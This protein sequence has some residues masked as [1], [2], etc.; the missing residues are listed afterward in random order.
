MRPILPYCLGIILLMV[1]P[2]LSFS[3][4]DSDTFCKYND[5][6]IE[7]TSDHHRAELLLSGDNNLL[8][9]CNLEVGETYIISG[10]G[11]TDRTCQFL[12]KIVGREAK[13]E[14]TNLS[15]DSGQAL[16]EFKA[17]TTCIDIEVS[18]STC[19]SDPEYLAYMTVECTSCNTGNSPISFLPNI[20][21][22]PNFSA[23][24]LVSDIFIG[25][26]CFDVSNAS[27]IGSD[28][29]AGFFQNAD[30]IGFGGGG[31]I[32]ASGN[33][34]DAPGPAGGTA[35]SNTAP[36]N[37]NDPD[38]LALSGNPN[39]NNCNGLEFDF[40][41]TLDALEFEFV[42]ASE[43]YCTFVGSQYN[44]AFGFFVSGPGIT[45]PY[46]LGAE[47]IA[48][49]PGTNTEIAINNV[50]QNIN[51]GFF[52]PNNQNSCGG[53]TNLND[54][55][56][57]G[58]TD[59]FTATLTGLVACETY[60][61]KLIVGDASDSAFDSAVFLKGKSFDA[62]GALDVQ[63][64]V[65][66][67]SG[68]VAIEACQDGEFLFFNGL[69]GPDPLTVNFTIGGTA[70]AG[71]DYVPF[72][73][74]ITIPAGAGFASILVDILPDAIAEGQ[75]T[76][77]ITL[78]D[79]A[80]SCLGQE[81]ILYID[82][83][84]DMMV[85]D[86]M[87]SVCGGGNTTLSPAITGGALPYT[88]SWSNGLGNGSSV[89]VSPAG[90]TTYTVTITDNCNISTEADFTVTVLSAPTA[91][92]SGNAALCAEDPN[93]SATL[94]VSFTGVGPWD[95]T[96]TLN[97]SPVTINGITDN[98]YDLVVTN[99]G[100]YTLSGVSNSFCTGAASGTVNIQNIDVQLNVI[101]VNIA[102][103]GDQTGS[104]DITPS[105]GDP[106]YT[107]AWATGEVTED[108]IN[109]PFG[110]YT[111]TVTDLNGCS[112]TVTTTLSEPTALSASI[113]EVAPI[114]CN[115]DL[116]GA[117]D[118]TVLGGAPG[119][120]TYNWSN[121]S[122][123]EDLIQL[124]AGTYTVTA[125]DMNNCTIVESITLTQPDAMTANTFVSQNVT[126]FGGNNGAGEL[127]VIGGTAPFFY[128]WSNGGGIDEDPTGLTAGDYTV[129][130]T[131]LSGCTAIGGISILQPP[132][133]IAQAD[134]TEGVSCANPTGGSASLIVV[135]G[136]PSYT[137]EW[138][139]GNPNQNP[140]NLSVGVNTVTITDVLG[141]MDT[142]EVTIT[143]DTLSP[144]ADISVIG[145]IS[146]TNSDVTLDG[147]GS[148]GNGVLSYEWQNA[149]GTI[150]STDPTTD[151]GASGDYTLI[152]T[153]GNNGCTAEISAM[154]DENSDV[155][156][157]AAVI[158]GV[159]SCVSDMATLDGSSSTGT[160]TLSYEWQN[161][162]GTV[163]ANVAETDIT[164]P[165]EYTLVVTE[166]GSGCTSSFLIDVPEDIEAPSP[167]ADAS[168]L[169]NCSGDP[170]TLDGS[171]S[172]GIGNLSYEW[173]DE[174][175]TSLG[176]GV[177]IDVSNSGTFTLV[178]TD[179]A[180]GC[181]SEVDVMV[182]ES[183]D[184]PTIDTQVSGDITCIDLMATLDGSGSTGIGTLTYEWQDPTGT[185]IGMTAEIDV[186][187]AG[188]YVLIITDSDN[189]CTSQMSVE[190]LEDIAAPSAAASV[191]DALDCMMT[192]VSLDGNASTGNGTLEY[193]WQDPDDIV[194]GATA[195][196]DVTV[197]GIYTLVITDMSNGC[198][199]ET[200]VE[201][202]E[203]IDPP[204]PDA[205]VND[206]LSCSGDPVTLDG[207][208]SSGN[209]TID[210]NWTDP[211]GDPAGTTAEVDVTIPGTY[212][213]LITDSGNGCT[214]ETT[215]NV[216][217]N[218]ATPSIDIASDGILT[219]ADMEVTL[220]GSASSGIGTITYE[221][222][223]SDGL[224]IG[225]GPDLD[226][227]DPDD[228]ILVITDTD[229]GCTAETS[230]M[231][232]QD[233]ATPTSNAGSGTSLTCSD[234]EVTLDGSGSTTVGNVSYEWL[235]NGGV[236]V[237]NA[238]T[239]EVTETGTYTLIVTNDDN[240][241]TASSTVDV[242]PDASL[243]T[244]NAG[245]GSAIT[246]I[247]D[248]VTL[249]GSASTS[250]GN[251]SY[252]WF[253]ENLVSISNDLVID[254]T[255]VGT[256]TLVV[257]NDDNGC[258]ASSSVEVSEDM[259]PPNADAGTVQFI[260]CTETDVT[261]DGSDSSGDNLSYQWLNESG[262]EVGTTVTVVVMSAETYTLIVTNGDNGCTQSTTVEVQT[263]SNVPVSNA[264]M[265]GLLNCNILNYTLDGSN[266][267][268]GTL[269]YEW[270]DPTGTVISTDPMI[271]VSISGTY[272]LVVTDT[273]NGCTSTST[274]FVDE[275]IEDPIAEAGLNGEI[276][277]DTDMATLDG[278]AST[279][280]TLSYVW[281]DATNAVVGMT[282][283]LT[284][285]E[286]GIYTLIITNE[287]N[288]CTATDQV[289]VIGSFE[290][291]SVDP[292]LDGLLTCIETSA[293]LD[294]S[295]ST[296]NGTIAYEWFDAS[297]VSLGNTAMV[298]TELPGIYTLI[299]TNEDNGCTES[300][301]VEVLENIATPTS[302]AGQGVT[303]TCSDTEVTLSGSGTTQSGNI[304]YE[305][306]NEGGVSI[307]VTASVQVDQ[308]GVYTLIVTDT[309]NGCTMTSTVS[310]VPDVNLPTASAGTSSTLTCL[311]EMATLDGSNSSTGQN[312]SYQWE[313]ASNAVIG[314]D[315]MLD[316]TTPGIY[317]IVV[318]DTN[319][320]CSSS[321]SVE[322]FE[323]IETPNANAGL[324][325][326]LS[327]SDMDAT[328]DGSGSTISTG[329]LA[330]EWQNP[331]GVT[332]AMT[333]TLDVSVSGIYTLIVTGD[334][335][336]TDTDVV[337]ILMDND[338]PVADVGLGGTLDCNIASIDLGGNGTSTGMGITHEWQDENGV[339]IAMT[340]TTSIATPGTY[341]LIVTNTT[342]GCETE[343]SI[344]IPEDVL[345][346]N[347]DAGNDETLTCILTAYEIGGLGTSMGPEFIY[348][349][350]NV[351]GTV[352]SND[353]VTE[354]TVD[355]TYTLLITN[356]TNG[357]T[358][359]EQVVVGIDTDTPVADAGQGGTLTCDASMVTLDGSASS[360]AN[361]EFEWL[362]E[363]GV[364]VSTLPVFDAGETGVYTLVVT[365]SANGCSDESTASIVPDANLPSAQATPSG[366]LTCVNGQVILDG[367]NSTSVSGNISY[368][369]QDDVQ[370]V[371]GMDDTY[372]TTTSGIYVL[373]VTDT[374]NGCT[375]STTLEVLEDVLPPSADAGTQQT[376]ICGQT[377]VT[378]TGIGGNGTNLIYEWQDDQGTVLSNTISV[379]VA[380]AGTYTFIVTNT[381]NGCT[382]SS[383]VSVVPDT[384]L[385][386]ADAG[387]T[388]TLTCEITT[389]TLDGNA[390]SQG[391]NFAY[392][393][394]DAS[395][396][397][398]ST[399]L[400]FDVTSPGTYT[401]FVL[402]TDNNCSS[403]DQ[404]VIGED[405]ND[406][407]AFA[408]YGSA[409]SLDCNNSSITLD[410]SG[411]S[412]FGSL[413]FQWSTVDGN[414]T[415]G[416][417]TINPEIN[418]PGTYDLVVTNTDN[419]CTSTTSITV[420]ENTE[421]PMVII[422]DPSMLTCDVIEVSIDASGSSTNGNYTYN[423]TG[424]GIV[425][426]TNTLTPIV[427][428]PGI[429]VCF[430]IDNDNGCETQASITVDENT[431]PPV[432]AASTQEMFDCLTESVSLSGAGSS[433]GAGISYEWTGVGTIDNETTLD[434]TVYQS[435]AFTLIVTDA[436]NGCTESEVVLVDE[437]TD[438]PS[439]LTMLIE[440]PQCFG[441]DGNVVVSEVVGG[442]APYLYSIDNGENFVSQNFFTNLAPG[443]YDLIVQDVNG[444]E[445]AED[446][447]ID[448]PIEIMIEIDTASS[449]L[450]QLGED[451]QLNALVNLDEQ[452][453]DTILWSPATGLSCTD[454]LDPIVTDA[455]NEITYT[456]TVINVN[457]CSETEEI[458]L[459][460]EKK[461]KVYIPNAFSP[462][463]GGANDIFMIYAGGDE[464]QEITTFQVFDRW[465]ELLFENYNF[466]P[467]D[468]AFGWNG[469]FRGEQLNPGVFVY[470]AEV[471]FIDGV[472]QIVK[473]DVTITK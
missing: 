295:G 273:D 16:L 194:I 119:G 386:T 343:Q 150:I 360:G 344:V 241:C 454:C 440:D 142:T 472:K 371:L 101:P 40:I 155:P 224:S 4:N 128:S 204:T 439:S 213:L 473:G 132:P 435:G 225:T 314:M 462:G 240:G 57:D 420:D 415:S 64:E 283:M 379:T 433:T 36:N 127:T 135:G 384:N 166:D 308:T 171:S 293:T 374:D 388:A 60:H 30:V 448:I 58:F 423:W 208:G 364:V 253:D 103:N 316:V 49:V 363:A 83:Y 251:I 411:S 59:V 109:V 461:R 177:D 73:N 207:S 173:F 180:N 327:C 174:T 467:N 245:L 427:N 45:G 326:T 317:T 165:G 242:T 412:P 168:G 147:T 331:D 347:A 455:F 38:L 369:W 402:N 367:T 351:A 376:L 318:T 395:G 47:N 1:F 111:V 272:T 195:D 445:Y 13:V 26:D 389:V 352:I 463:N 339:T 29:G 156:T 230:F 302:N 407:T 373:I 397:V 123:N 110:T 151:V 345:P 75:E 301:T 24:Q 9:F 91:T 359:T 249:D 136:N 8:T 447:F 375:S 315:A 44:D 434:P 214:A 350:T 71:V 160:G 69:G 453:I 86:E 27:I 381:D 303:L 94:T 401:L 353:P 163:I 117:I 164:T 250:T 446:L 32:L 289:E 5:D 106:T 432:A 192:P 172:T 185:V 279:G 277:C 218:V 92:L 349:W 392:E 239:V 66:G 3:S 438:V 61:I 116:T 238:I 413:T 226:V 297:N 311:V 414:I 184:V 320:G 115:G 329:G 232:D 382:T 125:T 76:I 247:V 366:M 288:G 46:S 205:T 385:P 323:N 291:P 62:G 145:L 298:T 391:A 105:G 112:E 148:T 248:E 309:D 246:C 97:G 281:E 292:G 457:G 149:S 37:Q 211:N 130:V 131:D 306:L 285:T 355:D 269:E 429:F 56:Y 266:S 299:I 52:N 35:S 276:D 186:A 398:I 236:T 31:V 370:T 387:T 82:D 294:G 100:S 170:V 2:N 470:W 175:D 284:A 219:C 337:E 189:G 340:P 399:D 342:S 235:N 409:Q 458:T 441:D 67:A 134:E 267:T 262:V 256:Y 396:T 341:T 6:P 50:N 325:S 12:S 203:S 33:V 264:G 98:P 405:V 183:T 21:V 424:N 336:C 330:Y 153:D 143:G 167:V 430:I 48:L 237:G 121:A 124:G 378:L 217:E 233:I 468:P 20:S 328:L 390:S 377:D 202:L 312:I 449:V 234:T 442:N 338:I 416:E 456:V 410:G 263:D 244:A 278:G 84:E 422:E 313:D 197:A 7:I 394:Q 403:Q 466:Q 304:A 199:A 361:I 23:D 274:A 216:L 162:G 287:D 300:S 141:C 452:D 261:L 220:D 400:M 459:R 188:D 99:Q 179:D 215:V 464:I 193:E 18:K 334:N 43:E 372:T 436:S 332:V 19:I 259:T 357:C 190:L 81:T 122:S 118:L 296:A 437:D 200:T 63:A 335:G 426:G 271:D 469:M 159:L 14:K 39:M 93:A 42:F 418:Q 324:G 268:G 417:L 104:I 87:T 95:I 169:I 460:V 140:D 319:N 310:V 114:N 265:D 120:Y 305:W 88:Y 146:C 53:T 286:A 307:G 321:S 257:T 346:P 443:S 137:F 322:V 444:C 231:L 368:E 74:S 108:L 96:Y 431:T 406:P 275:D 393:W 182:G 129:T 365:N 408:D 68:D 196:L 354:V 54:I 212:T 252:E 15:I 158:D 258:S 229:N 254:V 451:Y 65:Q 133:I 17:L 79:D 404:V 348:E 209:G 157:A 260:T 210:Y 227:A 255:I 333:A 55:E 113:F 89:D 90:T 280:G 228:Y 78:E 181:T 187:D 425:S 161:A 191:D 102:C 471:E 178:I 10:F 144:S 201:V 152:I 221:W 77:T 85:M 139:N 383:T 25:G 419:G 72:P 380:S 11:H 51:S 206:M 41:P 34:T 358:A 28:D 154:V 223:D 362:N 270:Q 138:S 107:Y 22:D 198:T 428:L 450:I 290:T 243:P 126:C 465:G 70:T 176:A 421:A 80:C 282:Q 356:T 222:F